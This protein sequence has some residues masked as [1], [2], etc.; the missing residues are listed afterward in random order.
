MESTH[1]EAV[2]M[3]T[4]ALDRVIHS[5]AHS[6]AWSV[7]SDAASRCAEE[8]AEGLD[9]A[10][11]LLESLDDGQR[12]AVLAGLTLRFHL[13]NKA[14]QLE[15]VRV[16]RERERLATAEAPRSES[17]DEAVRA[18][19]QA[20]RSLDEVLDLLGRIDI[21]PTLTAH[22]TEARR[23]TVLRKQKEIA[24]HIDRL[25]DPALTPAEYD[26]EVGEIDRLVALLLATDD[27]RTER[28]QVLE[29]VR[30]GLYFLTGS[31][32]QAV[33]GI[34]ADLRRAIEREYG[35]CPDELP[36]LLRYRSWIGGD[37]DG[38]SRVTPEVTR[39]TIDLMRAEAI[40]MHTSELWAL[41]ND[42]SLSD[43]RVPILPAFRSSI[44]ADLERYPGLMGERSVRHLSH[45]PFRIKLHLMIAKLA[46]EASGYTADGLVEDLGML[47]AAIE[48]AGLGGVLASGPLAD[49]KIRAKTFGLHLAALDIRQHSGR[50]ET[51]VTQLLAAAHTHP[52]YASLGEAKRIELLALELAHPRPLV[53]PGTPIGSEATDALATL[54]TARA[55]IDRDP[56]AIGAMIIS[57]T[58]EV[59]DMLELLVLMKE[60]GLYRVGQDSVESDADAVPL[61]ET[62]DDL[63]RAPALMASMYTSSAYAPQLAARGRF[64]E[65]MLGYSDS[66]KDGGFLMA[67]WSLQ[68]AQA[69]L[70]AAAAEHGVEQRFFHGRGG[71]VGRGGGRANRAILAAPAAAR[72]PH[73]RMTEQGEVISF[74]Y[75][76]PAIA[77]RH[78]EQIIGAVLQ[79]APS[80]ADQR[81]VA[82]PH[83]PTD[84]DSAL[85]G[86]LAERAMARY[87]ELVGMDGFWDW[88]AAATP[89]EHISG[90]PIASRPV[91]RGGGVVG[92]DNLRAI[93]WV[94][95][96]TQIRANLPG[97]FGIGTAFGEAI[98]RDG[99]ERLRGLY[100]AWPFF[101]ALVDNAA[102]ELARTRI[103]ILRRYA[104]LSPV[105]TPIA[106]AIGG[107]YEAAQDTVLAIT[108]RDTLIRS[109]VI[110][111]T[112]RQR[113]PYADT[114]NLL[115][116]GLLERWPDC[117]EADR[118]RLR[119][120]L[121]LSINGIAAAMQST[122]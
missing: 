20:G 26:S 11:A 18:M 21:M 85:L 31:I 113:N 65:I 12:A 96:W 58:H 89:I 115:Q 6:A 75:A 52:D 39:E 8:S 36:I 64:Q 25:R 95:A 55:A 74:R 98:E 60:A 24:A 23:R 119:R 40:E 94:F 67:N 3:L 43:R 70:G 51:A 2:R 92:L 91:S 99:A 32:W 103:T 35:S 120:L 111:E 93:P 73:L 72:S 114:I 17:L 100:N 4:R 121:F 88:Y 122:G 76:L 78:L 97:W 15:I 27:V 5:S 117:P 54:R 84:S 109:P 37:R 66:N 50:Y 61:F 34:Y 44:E 101:S 22:P 63:R 57:M 102:L 41:R 38:N 10:A 7:A 79:A 30:N 83:V 9:A 28:L 68:V 49:A 29:E 1:S 118:G 56:N 42:L 48:H 82:A 59:S 108:G 106:D 47:A 45:E 16:N 71:T 53:A 62:I 90:L 107:E 69:E 112:I 46:D 13:N 81:P 33:P 14:E 77:R 105:G 116:I 87:R 110:A 104:A 80:G 86:G 19:R